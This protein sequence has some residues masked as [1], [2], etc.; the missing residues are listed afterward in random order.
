MCPIPLD[1]E[2]PAI[3]KG[4]TISGVHLGLFLTTGELYLLKTVCDDLAIVYAIVAVSFAA[5]VLFA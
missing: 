4:F 1:R 2:A 3:F 5:V